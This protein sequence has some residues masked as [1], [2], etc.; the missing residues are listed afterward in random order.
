PQ[1]IDV[2]F[3][4]PYY[5]IVHFAC[6]GVVNHA[7]PLQSCLIFQKPTDSTGTQFMRDE[8]TVNDI[9]KHR[10]DE[11]DTQRRLRLVYLSACSSA[12]NRC[13]EMSDEPLHMAS[14]F[15]LAG[16]N[17]AVG[18]WWDSEDET[19]IEVAQKFY[20]YLFQ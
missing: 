12:A 16:F 8:L 6:H 3:R 5:N 10:L 14:V 2:L 4:L 1:S 17:H 9:L 15:L 18:T 13:L 7:D 19:C 11:N 20:E